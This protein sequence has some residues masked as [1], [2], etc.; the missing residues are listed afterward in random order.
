MTPLMQRLY[1]GEFSAEIDDSRCKAEWKLMRE[2]L[3]KDFQGSC[4]HDI[5]LLEEAIEECDSRLRLI[6]AAVLQ[7]VDL[8]P[9]APR[10]G[11][12]VPLIAPYSS[13]SGSIGSPRD[14]RRAGRYAA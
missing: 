9:A 2:K 5:E 11:A 3:I 12:R 7:R 1:F 13:L 8:L 4:L 10:V 6:H 14:A